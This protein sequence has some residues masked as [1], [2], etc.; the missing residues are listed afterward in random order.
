M[1]FDFFDVAFPNSLIIFPV[2]AILA[3]LGISA[4][5]PGFFKLIEYFPSRKVRIRIVIG[6]F[7]TM[8]SFALCAVLNNKK[9]TEHGG[10]AVSYNTPPAI[11]TAAADEKIIN[12]ENCTACNG[13]IYQLF[14][15][16]MTWTDAKAYCEELGGHLVTI[17]SPEEEELI[18][19]LIDKYSKITY[20]IGLTDNGKKQYNWV[21]GE[22]FDYHKNIELADGQRNQYTYVIVSARGEEVF[23]HCWGDHDSIIR[24]D[25][26]DYTKSGFIC[27]WDSSDALK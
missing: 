22:K 26:W 17:T 27:E 25:M 24:D 15:I 20:H 3:T 18:E 14:D 2:Y 1:D 16:S 13:H 11:E 23:I 12:M 9:S 21:T 7:V 4:A 19:S 5:L 10:T 8:E 6:I